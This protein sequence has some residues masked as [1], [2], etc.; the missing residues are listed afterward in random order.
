MKVIVDLDACESNAFCMDAAPDI[1]EVREDDLLYLLEDEPPEEA[2]HR[3]E[4]AV[5]RCPKR[6][7]SIQ[8]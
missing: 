8:N 7:I 4:L 1:F 3:V 6:A 5:E 2:R